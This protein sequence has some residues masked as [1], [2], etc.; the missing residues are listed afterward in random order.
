MAGVFL[1]P[2][3][4]PGDITL[5]YNLAFMSARRT[6]S[7]SKTVEVVCLRSRITGTSFLKDGI[8]SVSL[9]IVL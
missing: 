5:C 9:G 1:T 7:G 2:G 4:S 3:H 6:E 8:Y